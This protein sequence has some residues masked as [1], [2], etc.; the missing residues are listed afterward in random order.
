MRKILLAATL[1]LV[2]AIPAMSAVTRQ[3]MDIVVYQEQPIPGYWCNDDR[4]SAGFCQ[5]CPLRILGVCVLPYEN[6]GFTYGT[7]Y[8][9]EIEVTE[10]PL[11]EI[12]RVKGTIFSAV[13][14]NTK[15]RL[16][17]KVGTTVTAKTDW[18]NQNPLTGSLELQFPDYTFELSGLHVFS[19]QIKKPDGTIISTATKVF[20]PA[21]PAPG[22]EPSLEEEPLLEESIEE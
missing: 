11:G 2:M 3:P 18:T 5:H 14:K 21:P 15:Y 20:V 7:V 4:V 19:L 13:A 12:R 8:T 9:D 10:V 6:V 22:A 1:V 17:V 16:L